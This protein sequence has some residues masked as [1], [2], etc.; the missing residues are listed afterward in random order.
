VIIVGSDT[1]PTSDVTA[2]LAIKNKY[3]GYTYYIISVGSRNG[4]NSSLYPL[5]S[6]VSSI[7]LN[8]T[9]KNDTSPPYITVSDYSQLTTLD[10]EMGSLKRDCDRNCTI[11]VNTALRWFDQCACGCDK[12]SNVLQIYV[13]IMVCIATLR[14]CRASVEAI[15]LVVA[16]EDTP[17]SSSPSWRGK[18]EH[19]ITFCTLG[20]LV[21]SAFFFTGE[22]PSHW[23]ETPM[24]AT[25]GTIIALMAI[26]PLFTFI[27]DPVGSVTDCRNLQLVMHA[28][29]CCDFAGSSPTESASQKSSP[30]KEE[31]L[32]ET[33]T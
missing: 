13:F 21:L 3:P 29:L 16:N 14:T 24:L 11:N 26:P 25:A 1:T 28:L 31:D 4:T 5:S 15:K 22:C 30:V 32:K 2:T 19:L 6:T 20:L 23:T 7:S 27:Q 18:R 10:T 17:R 33:K 9:D 12:Q 8:N